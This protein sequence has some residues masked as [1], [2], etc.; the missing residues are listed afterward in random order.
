MSLFAG[1]GALAT[2]YK[3]DPSHTNARFSIDHFQTSS[4]HGG[5]YGIAGD[6]TFDPKNEKGAVE[7][8]FQ[9]NTLNTGFKDFD[10]HMQSADI[11]DV[12][13]FPTI[14]FQST[15]WIFKD[16]KPASIEGNLTMMGKTHP[17]TLTAEKFGCYDNPMFKAQVCGGDF[18]ATIDRT[19]WGIDFLMDAGIPKEV[20]LQIQVE[21]VKQ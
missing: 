10:G 12:A 9:T 7:V 1:G 20:H 14:N 16:G 13:K 11:L 19:Q 18:T 17:I 5:F 4:N 6:I 2:E 3:I 21:A 8:T 15:Q